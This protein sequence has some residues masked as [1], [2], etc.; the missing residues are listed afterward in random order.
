MSVGPEKIPEKILETIPSE[1]LGSLRGCLVEGDAEQRQ[2]ERRVRRRALAISIV[3]QTAVLTI[4]VLVPLFAKT[5]RIAMKN[6]VP[7]PPYGRPSNPTHGNNKPANGPTTAT[8]K[9]FDFRPLNYNLHP[10]PPGGEP[11]VAPGGLDPGGTQ[12]PGGPGCNRCVDL[13]ID[14]KGPV[15]PQQQVETQKRPQIVHQTT[16]DPAM[17]I[18]RVEP[19][20][21]PLAKQIHKE[22]RVELR[23]IIGTDG[24][25]QSLQ[26]V[27]GDPLFLISAREAV[28][29]WRYKPTYLNGQ[30]VEID[31][32]IT[33]VYTMQH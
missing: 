19:V 1:G 14:P 8:A 24:T 5:E 26:V 23:A 25:I 21:P 11:P 28:E 3:L 29:Q 13:G 22:G 12:L 18:R 16:I 17:L 30:P 15:P 31:T 4:L 2:R 33:V 6:F 9:H 32:F 20:Y 27:S 7:M 10:L